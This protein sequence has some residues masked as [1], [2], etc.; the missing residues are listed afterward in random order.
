[1]YGKVREKTMW[2]F[3]YH[4]TDCPSS[5]HC[6]VPPV[7]QMCLET[8]E[9]N[10][11]DFDFRL[12]HWDEVDDYV[13]RAELPFNW[14]G[15]DTA[16]FMKDSLMHALL[17]RYGG[18]M[19]DATMILFEPL[20][21][22]WDEMVASGAHWRGFVYPWTETAV[23]LV[24]SR[25]EGLH[26]SATIAQVIG[27]GDHWF[28][29]EYSNGSASDS[30]LPM[31]LAL[32][33]STLTPVLAMYDYRLSRCQYEQVQDYS[34]RGYGGLERWLLERDGLQPFTYRCYPPV[35]SE[36]NVGAELGRSQIM[37]SDPLQTIQL[38]YAINE[39]GAMTLWKIDEKVDE[40][41]VFLERFF[42]PRHSTN[43]AR[44]MPILKLFS[45]GGP[46]KYHTREELIAQHDTFLCHWLCLANVNPC[47]I[48]CSGPNA[49]GS[50]PRSMST[51]SVQRRA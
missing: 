32:G 46:A 15:F 47:N 40:W 18:V 25:R 24:M 4:P 12:V 30:L 28:P 9:K 33:H 19:V 3:W 26:R 17:A 41:T 1:M 37:Y 44:S 21:S 11:G 6:V 8:Y 7:V 36:D 22:W 5:K 39:S 49:N 42:S 10:K 13:S 2:A 31:Y 35:Q 51:D 23:Y 50:R 16:Q 14:H 29:T 34:Y 48:D 38:P 27:M 43:R 45:T 20:D